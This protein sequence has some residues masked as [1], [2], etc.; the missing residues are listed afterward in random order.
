[1]AAIENRD[2]RFDCSPEK[3]CFDLGRSEAVTFINGGRL[4]VMYRC[5]REHFEA[6]R[7]TWQ[8]FSALEET[9]EDTHLGLLRQIRIETGADRQG[10]AF[11]LVFALPEAYPLF[12]WRIGVENRGQDPVKIDRITMLQS[13]RDRECGQVRVSDAEQPRL[14]FYANGWQSWNW[15]AVY[16]NAQ[17]QRNTRL[18]PIMGPMYR[19]H[20][21]PV[22]RR[23]GHFSSDFF[24]VIG[25]RN[26]RVGWLVG[27]LSQRQHFGSLECWL[28][29]ETGLCVWANGDEAV[30]EAGE[31]I[32]TD[33]AVAQPVDLDRPDPLGAYT[34][35]AAR[36]NGVTLPDKVPSGWCSWYYYYLNITEEKIRRNLEALRGMRERL[37]L[38][39]VQIDDGFEKQVGDWFEFL[40][41]F[42]NGVAPLAADI[43]RDGFMPGLWL[44]PFIVHPRSR[45]YS[46]HPDWILRDGHGRHVSAGYNWGALRLAALDLTMPEALDYTRRVI[47]TAAHEW[48]FPYLKLDFL[49]AGGLAGKRHNPRFTRAQVLRR[50]LEALREAAGRETFLLGCGVPIGSS[51]GLFD[52]M[53]IGADVAGDWEPNYMGIRLFFDQETSMPSARNAV[54]NV[55]TRAFQNRRWWIN[56]P[57]C[58]L[59]RAD[60]KLTLAEIQTL[61]TATA[62]TGGSLLLSDDLSTL[63]PDRLR[64][65]EALLPMLGKRPEMPDWFDRE[66]PSR[67]K[68][69]L[70]GPE[71]GWTLIALFNWASTA[72]EILFRPSDFR[73]AEGDYWARSFWDGKVYRI[74]RGL[75][76]RFPGI[77]AHGCVLLALRIA[78]EGKARYLGGDLHFSQG[79]EVAEW[80][81]EEHGLRLRLDLERRTEGWIELALPRNPAAVRVDGVAVKLEIAR[82]GVY[83]V[84][85]TG[86]SEV[87]FGYSGS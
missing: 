19:N 56:D 73:L 76:L 59:V 31:R 65:A 43:A 5:G 33:W 44:A 38:D 10:M 9:V 82:E 75:P 12:L 16:G 47:T 3:G 7:D 70:E 80:S 52:A 45:L 24:G 68:L 42:P 63:S 67:I 29:E 74:E 6:L 37:P 22:T 54:Q 15:S 86:Q 51:I 61:A 77:P 87:T 17:R 34:E 49:Y 84:H 64:I 4:G 69:D 50:G 41:G 36:V 62:M 35:A 58:L 8:T 18:G 11:H 60:T 20:S 83:R 57:D 72:E 85:V 30:L 46:E 66:T 55:L 71:G 39:L 26:A 27:F 2:F 32:D 81:E 14:A 79:S 78:N 13:G 25:D 48:G 21:T 1:M 28:G 23:A 53:R 40:P